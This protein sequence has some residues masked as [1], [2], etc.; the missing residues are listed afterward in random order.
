MG[1]FL[2]SK[3]RHVHPQRKLTLSASF[4]VQAV[5]ILV[6]AALSQARIVPAFSLK[7]LPPATAALL[8]EH[9][10][11]ESDMRILIPLGLLAFQFGGQIVSSRQLGFNEVP[12]NVLTSV[13][14]D[15]L[16]DPKLFAPL[17]ENPKRNRR[18]VAVV[19]IVVGAIAGG[20]LQRSRAGM[21]T[22]LW[23]AGAIKVV[24]AVAWTGWKSRE[25]KV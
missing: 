6:A 2:F 7:S 20:W 16:S 4:L 12:T 15:L 17:R 3:L 25:T 14:C 22:A 24:I 8:P 23:I 21:S 13:Y 18:F 10:L 19:M 11:D 9:E 5:F 1:C